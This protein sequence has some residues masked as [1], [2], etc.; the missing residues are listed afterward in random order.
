MLDPV[1]VVAG[2]IRAKLPTIELQVCANLSW[3]I[4]NTLKGL[5]DIKE[6]VTQGKEPTP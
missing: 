5:G 4:V 1:S 6:Q 2:V 3:E